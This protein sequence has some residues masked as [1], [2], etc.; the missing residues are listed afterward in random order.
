LSD[1]MDLFRQYL[2]GPQTGQAPSG[3]ETIER[4]YDRV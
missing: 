1:K 3:A 4:L 2:T